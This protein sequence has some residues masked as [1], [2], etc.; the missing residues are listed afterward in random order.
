MIKEFLLIFTFATIPLLT[1]EIFFIS[2][3]VGFLIPSPKVFSALLMVLQKIVTQS[4]TMM[5][6]DLDLLIFYLM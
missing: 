1:P 4:V 3:L 6:H 5:L 2:D